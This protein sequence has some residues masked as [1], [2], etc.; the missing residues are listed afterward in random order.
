[1]R[2]F[3]CVANTLLL[4]LTPPATAAASSCS[5]DEGCE[6]NGK[7]LSGSCRC[8]PGWMGPTCG[9]LKL[10]PAPAMSGGASP[11]AL[12]PQK[13]PLPPHHEGGPG[14]LP[15]SAQARRELPPEA[16]GPITWGGT[17]AT[18]SAGLHHLFV[19]VCCYT[20]TTIMHDV[21]GCQ[22]IHATST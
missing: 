7:C 9:T 20:P 11:Y 8:F 12:Y 13:R 2:H 16:G 6:L 3:R 15:P 19:D 22:T 21:N 10:K 18:D 5:S 1:M 14:A 17:I 4:L